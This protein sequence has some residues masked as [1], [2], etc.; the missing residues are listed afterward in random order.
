MD[1]NISNIVAS[2]FVEYNDFYAVS[3]QMANYADTTQFSNNVILSLEK[4]Y[5]G[6]LLKLKLL[7]EQTHQSDN[8]IKRMEEEILALKLQVL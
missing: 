2:S 4:L 5:E 1:F 6:T 8:E 3:S 7:S